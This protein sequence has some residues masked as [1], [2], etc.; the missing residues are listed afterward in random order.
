MRAATCS[1][2]R[3]FHTVYGQVHTLVPLTLP[4]PPRLRMCHLPT[5]PLQA[6]RSV[7]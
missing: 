6:A 7:V 1:R 5:R 2:V 3:L 4:C